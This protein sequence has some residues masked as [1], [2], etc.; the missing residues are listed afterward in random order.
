MRIRQFRAILSVLL[1]LALLLPNAA[2]PV[3]RAQAS[4]APGSPPGTPAVQPGLPG[5]GVDFGFGYQPSPFPD[6]VGE[7][8]AV[9]GSEYASTPAR[10]GAL[11][12]GTCTS[13]TY[14]TLAVPR[15]PEVRQIGVKSTVGAPPESRDKVEEV[16][17]PDLDALSPIEAAFQTS[18][19]STTSL[20]AIV[21]ETQRAPQAQ[22]V[23]S[24]Y[25]PI[26]VMSPAPAAAPARS[27]VQAQPVPQDGEA[28][29]AAIAASQQQTAARPNGGAAMKFLGPFGAPLRQY[30][31]AVFASYVSTFAPIDD[32]PVGP[33]YV[34]GPGDTLTISLWGQLENTVFRTVDRNGQ[35]LLPR[36]GDL[37]VWGLTFAQADRVIREQLSRYFR[38]FQT[39][40]TMGRLRTMRVQVIGEVCQPGSYTVNAL[41]TLTQALYSAGGPTK[42]GSLRN[43][44][45]LRNSH[46]VGEIDLYDFLLRGD[47]S[48]DYR[49][50][51]GDT[52]FV[53][54]IG[55]T[56]AVA[57]EVKR[58]AIYEIRGDVRLADLVETAGGA[59]PTSYLKRIQIVRAQPSA[60]RVTVDVDLSSY[61]LK[62]DM[63]AN[64]P[65]HAGDLVLVH[66]NEGRIYNTVKIDGAVKYPGVY[67]LKPMMRLSQLVPPDR[68]LPESYADK[69]EIARR[70]PDF[71]VEVLT[72]NLREA[73]KGK[74]EQ[75]PLLRANDEVTIRT[76]MR[77]IRTVVLSGQIMRPGTYVIAEGEKLSSV[78]ERAGGFT[79][80]ASLKGAV[81]TRASLRKVE[82]EQLN[83]FVMVQ[84]QRILADASTTVAGMDKED[85]AI[86]SSVVQ[87]RRD[88]LRAL[89]SRVAVGR[90]V[91]K[92][93]PAD[94]IKG[95][96]EDI[97]LVDGDALDVPEPIDS[98]LVLGSVRSSTSVLHA[99]GANVDYYVNRVGGYAKEADKKETHIVR[100]DGSAVSGFSNIRTVEPGDTILVPRS[101]ESK[102]RV[103]PAIRDGFSILG[104]TLSTVT[105]L[106]A[107]AVLFK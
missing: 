97:M 43:V 75:D 27:G 89:A 41:S 20:G 36:V 67:E 45:L 32:V 17:R 12:P 87:A 22:D 10:G 18:P 77:S 79:S 104:S 74:L 39:S 4:G 91:I 50:E 100:A 103:F 94:Q 49:L 64:P 26:A 25:T 48:R 102:F 58:P 6:K 9:P 33:D 53:P 80:R 44:R 34:I 56:A 21:F 81:F 40:V 61:Y 37:R 69:V 14:T 90:M 72:V 73:W 23:V 13:Q 98:V 106:A 63:E 29:R 82:Q 52:I 78:L 30:G 92:V 59:T 5:G 28:I 8:R 57:G 35:I 68:L 7:R 65:V 60:E 46:V 70:R 15:G 107:L 11:A 86:G 1:T 38:G 83:A 55:D 101:E 42:L 66:K 105:S 19:S 47:R 24:P 16:L 31:Y 85:A 2:I 99:P 3:A 71:S 51:A 95:T 84:E 96:V 93:S 88:F 54:T 62:G 76:E